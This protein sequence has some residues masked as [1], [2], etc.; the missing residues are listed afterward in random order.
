M[1]PKQQDLV[2]KVQMVA[3]KNEVALGTGGGTLLTVTLADVATLAEQIGLICGGILSF[4]VLTNWL[5]VHKPFKK[6]KK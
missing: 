5:W 6:K 3:A 1:E 4:L 2:Q